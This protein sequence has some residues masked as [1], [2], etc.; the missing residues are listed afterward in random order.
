MQLLNAISMA[1]LFTNNLKNE[2]DNYRVSLQ[3][4]IDDVLPIDPEFIL[5]V[6]LILNITLSRAPVRA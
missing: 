3:E 4:A 5:K 1:L 6:I 2:D